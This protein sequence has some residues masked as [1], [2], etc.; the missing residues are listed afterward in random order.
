MNEVI[1]R[2]SLAMQYICA[3]RKTF[4]GRHEIS[5]S[6]RKIV[7][8]HFSDIHGDVKRMENAMAVFEYV[9]PD[10]AIHTGDTAMWNTSDDFSFFLEMAQKCSVPVYTCIGNHDT[11]NNEGNNDNSFLHESFIKKFGINNG[12][13]GY[14]YI[15]FEKIGI[16][17][18][19]LNDYEYCGD[20]LR[21]KYAVL[22]E[23]C[24]WL[25]GV[26]KESSDKG[27][28][29]IIAAHENEEDIN[30]HSANNA[31]CQRAAI[32]PW[33]LPHLRPHPAADIVNAFKHGGALKQTYFYEYNNQGFEIDCRFDKNGEFICWLCGDRHGDFAGYLPSYPEQL[34]ITVTCSGC[35]PEG[36]HNIG[37][38]CSD[39]PRIPD[40]VSEDAI[41]FYVIDAEKHD[42]CAIRVGAYINDRFEHRLTEHF[43]Y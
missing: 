43:K 38:E 42:L 29:I 2:N 41:N 1:L 32:Y 3:A 30:P 35:F 7:I 33:G 39:L 25:I 34:S 10:F 26:L 24:E 19:I 21:D 5:Y 4:T 8:G 16:R 31:F 17:L 14:G 37:E 15:D 9:K 12:K 11:F 20:M 6:D 28:K 40:T 36:Y 22:K 27:F 23:Q 13:N 18:V